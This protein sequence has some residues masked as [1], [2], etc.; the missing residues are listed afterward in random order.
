[1][2][3]I[4]HHLWKKK[5]K[6]SK[7]QKVV[8]KTKKGEKTVTRPRLPTKY[9]NQPGRIAFKRHKKVHPGKVRSSLQ[10]GR[11]AIILSGKYAGKRVV[12]VKHLPSRLVVVSGPFRLNRVPLRRVD[13]AYLIG[14]S[15]QIN[16]PEVLKNELS[17][18]T[19]DHFSKKLKAKKLKQRKALSKKYLK[20]KKE[21]SGDK[22]AE[23]SETGQK[24][25]REETDKDKHKVKKRKTAK[26]AFQSKIDSP[27]MAEIKKQPELGD[28]MRSRF[29][30]TEGQF[31]HAL[32]F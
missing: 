11:I 32:K 20:E 27:L 31:P 25:K 1:M 14:T 10:P 30:L 5:K 24:R 28:Y 16:L 26:A 3:E 17:E 18:I 9:I 7:Y 2:E 23:K 4:F 29:F 6:P 15:V 13:A 21:K 19:D 8:I 12:V 22:S